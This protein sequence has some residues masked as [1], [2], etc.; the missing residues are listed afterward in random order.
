MVSRNDTNKNWIMDSGCSF[1]MKLNKGWF[2]TLNEFDE[3]QVMLGNNKSFEIKGVG[4]VRIKFHDGIE[5]VLNQ[6]RY[7]PGLRR[8]LISLG[9]LDEIG[10][11]YKAVGCVLTV[12]RDYLMIMKGLKENGLYILQGSIVIGTVSTVQ[13]KP[14]L[15]SLKWHR[16]LA[17]VCERGLQELEKQGLLEGDKLGKLEFCEYCIMGKATRLKF[18]RVV[19]STIGILNYIHADL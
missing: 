18:T 10:Y 13:E 3:G 7:I 19:H 2:K 12:S 6:V 15:N 16:R 1:H 4:T 17:H 8:N 11:S 9:T 14:D 5:R